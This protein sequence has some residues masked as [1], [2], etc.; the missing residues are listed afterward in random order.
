MPAYYLESSALVK[1][2]SIETGSKFVIGLLRPSAKNRFYSAKI[3]EVEV[4]AALTRK[5]KGLKMSA[6]SATKALFRF[7]RNFAGSFNKPDLTDSIVSE[8]VRLT[9]LYALR[10]YDAVQLATALE[11]NRK[12][13]SDGLSALVFVSADAE[14]NNA[15]QAEGLEVENPNNYP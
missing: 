5:R 9:E 15:A 12:R 4:C 7:R 14:L 6:A 2:Y 10:G 13:L 3:T 11:T 8:A 1:R